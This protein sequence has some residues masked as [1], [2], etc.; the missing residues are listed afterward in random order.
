M[1][2]VFKISHEPIFD[3]EKVEEFYTKKDGVEVKYA[4]TTELNGYPCGDVFYRETPHPEF[5][6]RYFTLYWGPTTRL[7]RDQEVRIA[8]ADSI[9]ELSFGMIQDSN[10]TYHYSSYRHH[11][12][13]VDNNFIDGGRVYIRTSAIYKVF[14]VKDG[15]FCTEK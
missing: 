11:Y 6:N 5:G 1:K 13:V 8:N 3:T 7:T 4:C 10:G 9:E 2:F 14:K 12:N 15:E